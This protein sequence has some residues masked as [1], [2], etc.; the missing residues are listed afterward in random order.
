MHARLA[1][2]ASALRH[3][4]GTTHRAAACWP[5]GDLLL[6]ATSAT[7]ALANFLQGQATFRRASDCPASLCEAGAP[8]VASAAGPQGAAVAGAYAAGPRLRLLR[9]AGRLQGVHAVT[10]S[11]RILAKHPSP[12][13]M[14]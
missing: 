7:S 1:C 2:T 11:S 3:Q 6:R 9:L 4:A 14:Q 10:G 13:Q 12:Q 8:A 5:A